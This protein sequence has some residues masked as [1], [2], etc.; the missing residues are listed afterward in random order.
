MSF[1]AADALEG[2]RTGTRGYD[3]A[4]AYVASR[5]EALGLRA[6]YAG[7]YFQQVPLRQGVADASKSELVLRLDGREL[8]LQP[9]VDYLP[10][11]N[12]AAAE[13]EIEA[14]VVFVGQGVSAPERGYDDYAGVDVRGK[15]VLL[16]SG[17]PASF[18]TDE[19]AHY[20]NRRGKLE[21][22]IAHGALGILSF[23]L[24]EDLARY[25]WERMRQ[26]IAK[27]ASSWRRPDGGV[28]GASPAWRGSAVL[29][30]EPSEAVLGG[31]E[32]FAAAVADI[33]A[34]RSKSREL[35]VRARLR[36][37]TAHRDYTSPN[38][39]GVLEGSDPAQKGEAVVFSAHLDHEGLG[40][41]VAGD[42]VWN[43]FFDNA[44]GIASLL[45]IAGVLAAEPKRPR[46]S[47]LFLA[48]TGEEEG[49][50]GSDYFARNPH[51]RPVANVNTDMFLA[52]LPIREIMAFGAEHSS[53]GPIVREEARQAGFRLVA[54]P[55]PRETLF[56]RSDQYSFVKQ[57]VPSVAIAAGFD[58]ADAKSA[59]GAAIPNWMRTTYH[60]PGDDSS[61][62]VDWDSLVRY[63]ELN[64]RIGL[65]LADA[66][67]PPA[68]N[69]GDFF[70]RLFGGMR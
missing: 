4:A 57:G 26:G 59:A 64:R 58:A 30:A 55:F 27:G 17:A 12:L 53:L 28:E 69:P 62:T 13:A 70:G 49:L 63:T 37:A 11:P 56:V 43:G 24:P 54:D 2:R 45:E 33:E 39:V 32:A 1:L 67:A 51:L 25:P 65:R 60:R 9:G 42:G 38:V 48:C 8:R 14:A 36:I 61:Q 6:P 47:I 29:N 15:I 16:T 7:G 50:L 34:G 66:P 44:S 46:R 5:F 31:R 10:T 68:W 21:N 18:P 40:E 20:S 3:L 52:L 41:P 35:P 22:A 23:V 19:R